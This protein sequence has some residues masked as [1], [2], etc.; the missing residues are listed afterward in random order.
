MSDMEGDERKGVTN[1]KICIVMPVGNEEETIADTLTRIL[2]LGIEELF[3]TPVIDD[4]SQDNTRKI[5]EDFEKQYPKKIKL[6]YNKNATGAIPAYFYG[7]KYALKN[8]AKY[9]IEM[10][11]GNSHMPEQIPSFL[12]KLEEGYDCVFGSRFIEGGK[13]INHPY[14]R[15]FLSWLGTKV[16]NFY[17]GT[18]LKDM[19]S[20]FE[21]F[22]AEVLE[23]LN[24]DAFVSTGHFYQTE[25]RY[26][27]KEF[28][29]TEVPIHYRGSKSR[30][31]FNSLVNAVKELLKVKRNYYANILPNLNKAKG[32]QKEVLK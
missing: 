25:M 29:A 16:A 8:G 14:Y 28:N 13:F 3:V 32:K 17:L 31:S 22:R 18:K 30:F 24:F 1:E 6:L 26:Y 5:I 23:Q 7:F 4:Y 21:A 19:T 27:C 20:G 11:A 12:E 10:D 9:I 2:K 15:V